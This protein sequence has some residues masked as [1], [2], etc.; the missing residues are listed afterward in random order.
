[1]GDKLVASPA[2]DA[3]SR[4]WLLRAGSA[5]VGGS[6][7]KADN[8]PPDQLLVMII[9]CFHCHMT[10][11]HP[12]ASRL[13]CCRPICSST[14]S[15]RYEEAKSVTTH[16]HVPSP[17][18]IHK[19]NPQHSSRCRVRCLRHLSGPLVLTPTN[20]GKHSGGSSEPINVTGDPSR[21]PQQVLRQ[22]ACISRVTPLSCSDK[23]LPPQAANITTRYLP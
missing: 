14:Q 4:T 3:A 22:P 11:L 13:S 9:C 17:S 20:R 15:Q 7:F 23:P 12:L 2:L 19:H 21:R 10:K 8:G 18:G 5:Q 6:S 16:C 1:M